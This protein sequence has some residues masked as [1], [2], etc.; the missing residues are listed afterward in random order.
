ME[1][2]VFFQF[3]IHFVCAIDHFLPF[4]TGKRDCVGQ[5][6]AMKELMIVLAMVFMKYKINPPDDD[7]L[8]KIEGEFAG[9]VVEPK[10]Q[11][12]SMEHWK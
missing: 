11:K 2:S 7:N 10:V 4:H 12:V 9:Q 5:A 6:L 8:D 1:C 3:D